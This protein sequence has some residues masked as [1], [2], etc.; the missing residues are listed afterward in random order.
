VGERDECHAHVPLSELPPEVKA[1]RSQSF[2]AV[3]PAYERYRPTPPT[4][5]VD[6]LVPEHT[7][8]IV[9]LGAGTGRLT[10]L[11]VDRAD[12]VVA[13]EPDERMRAVLVDAVPGARPVDGTGESIPLAGR[14]VDAVL[15]A[16]SWHWMDPVATLAEVAR[17]L[18]PGGVLGVMWTGPDRMGRTVT[19]AK[20]VH[21][22]RPGVDRRSSVDRG[23]RGGGEADPKAGELSQRMMTEVLR[24]GAVFEIPSGF[25][26][27]EPEHR[28]FPW[29]VALDADELIGLLGTS[30]WALT[31][32]E[33]ERAAL[34]VETR[35]F[36][37][38]VMGIEAK[39]KAQV[40]FSAEVWRAHRLR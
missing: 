5:T 16:T 18:V 19:T 32:P 30:S 26:F 2:G 20:A 6:W 7:G 31:L 21:D 39:V 11:L 10:K 24:P 15:A 33:N 37:A 40:P 22:R 8:R 25:P 1:E 29:K 23:P 27:D 12:E 35:S 17:V 4:A 3:A 36:L 38:E 28:A 14:S 34:F 9:D 13:V